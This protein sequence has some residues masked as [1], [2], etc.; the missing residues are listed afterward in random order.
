MVTKYLEFLLKM[1]VCLQ[2]IDKITISFNIFNLYR[3]PH[4]TE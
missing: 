4:E 1:E 2:K 3:F